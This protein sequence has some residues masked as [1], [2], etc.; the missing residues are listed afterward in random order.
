YCTLGNKIFERRKGVHYPPVELYP[1]INKLLKDIVLKRI[2]SI[3]DKRPLTMGL[4]SGYDS[5]AIFYVLKKFN[6]PVFTYTYGQAGNLDFDFIKLFCD[7]YG[8]SNFFIDTSTVAW[9]L[10]DY[11]ANINS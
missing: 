2:K 3:E 9:S 1:I 10:D 11:Q 6:V 4:S 8:I 5:R 7:R